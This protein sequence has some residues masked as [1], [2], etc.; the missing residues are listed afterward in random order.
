MMHTIVFSVYLNACEWLQCAQVH[1]SL[2]LSYGICI[3][4]CSRLIDMDASGYN[5]HKSR[6]A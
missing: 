4:V 2:S 3:Q 1:V 5:A 6:R